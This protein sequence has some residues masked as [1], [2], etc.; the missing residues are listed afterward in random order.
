[1]NSVMF[2]EIGQPFQTA[3]GDSLENNLRPDTPG[4]DD[5]FKGPGIHK[6]HDQIYLRLIQ[7]SPGPIISDQVW[8]RVNAAN[9]LIM[10]EAPLQ[11]SILR[12]RNEVTMYGLEF[13]H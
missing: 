2:P 11:A 9:C 12:H 8:T 3:K 4:L 5:C 6:L 13:F 1:M 10:I 7:G